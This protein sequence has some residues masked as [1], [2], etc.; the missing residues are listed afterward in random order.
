[1]FDTFTRKFPRDCTAAYTRSAA[2]EENKTVF[3]WRKLHFRVK[4]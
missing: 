2:S 1:M 4:K 3:L